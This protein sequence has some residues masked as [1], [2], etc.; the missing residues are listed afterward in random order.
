MDDNVRYIR[1]TIVELAWTQEA[2]DHIAR[3]GVG[4]GG[5]PAA[6]VQHVADVLDGR[7]WR[8]RGRSGTTLVYGRTRGGRSLLVVL[9]PGRSGAAG[10]VTARDLTTGERRTLRRRETGR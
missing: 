9:A 10:V 4:G 5:P 7:Y 6:T 1:W 3:H 2:E 8:A